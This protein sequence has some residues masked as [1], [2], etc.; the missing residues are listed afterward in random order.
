MLK[1]VTLTNLPN[2]FASESLPLMNTTTGTGYPTPT[3]PQVLPRPGGRSIAFRSL[4]Q[5]NPQ[6][7][8]G[9]V[10]LHGLMSDMEGG[11]ALYMEQQC[12]MQG[13]AFI[14]FDQM[15]HGA[16]SGRFDEGT[17]GAWAEDTLAVLDT[18]T[19]GPQVLIGSSMGG[20]L[21]LLAARARP[22][23]IAGLVGI[24]AAPDF[25]EDLTWPA[26]SPDQ[27]REVEVRGRVEIPCPYSEQP[28]VF[29]EA[30]FRDG[31]KNLVLKD[32]L[33]FDGPVRLLHGQQDDS[34]PWERS[35]LLA[36]RLTSPDVDCI[37]IKSGDHRLSRLQDLDS[38]DM[39][40]TS[41]LRRLE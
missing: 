8:T 25:T 34:V 16:S 26:L 38:L 37:L 21:M 9:V 1:C 5:T 13:R 4:T 35:L 31:R 30:L 12:K 17:V 11:K 2:L 27:R 41:V 14:R 20:W 10:F 24:A 19:R 3:K 39:A 18:L 33:P 29:T 6:A 36:E 32:A 28:Y 15:G 40:L 22:H 7:V 23:R